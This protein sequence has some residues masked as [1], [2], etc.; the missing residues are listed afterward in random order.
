[1]SCTFARMDNV[2]Q[3]R[4]PKTNYYLHPTSGP[5]QW[6][7]LGYKEC[8]HHQQSPI[9]IHSKSVQQK[10]LQ[11]LELHFFDHAPLSANVTNNYVGGEY[12][13]FCVMNSFLT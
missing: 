11:P 6:S 2:R 1:M 12:G 7:R 4:P 10:H 9:D 3:T 13:V 5:S 8:D